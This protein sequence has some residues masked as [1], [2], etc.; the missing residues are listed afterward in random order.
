MELV[1]SLV[2]D[3]NAAAAI[4]AQDESG[5]SALHWASAVGA[6]DVVAELCMLP[7]INVSLTN[8]AGET[9]FHLAARGNHKGVIDALLRD[10]LPTRALFL[11]TARHE[12][13]GATPE[14][15]ARERGFADMAEYLLRLRDDYALQQLQQE[16]QL[17]QP[18]LPPPAQQYPHH[19]AVLGPAGAALGPAD[20]DVDVG[21]SASRKRP[22]SETSSLDEPRPAKKKRNRV[23]DRQRINQM[24]AKVQA[25]TEQH[26]QLERAIAGMRQQA[27]LLKMQANISY[28]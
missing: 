18:P 21:S 15:M 24:E 25:L 20:A 17:A 22:A 1:R 28:T 9:S 5:W 26:Q 12:V 7:R 3:A 6:A 14:D 19:E 4:N 10:R 2:Q 23:T 13:T 27:A 11:I 16:Q 8:N